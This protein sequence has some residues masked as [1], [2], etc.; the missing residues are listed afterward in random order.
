MWN[1]ILSAPK[2]TSRGMLDLKNIEI[3]NIIF[4]YMLI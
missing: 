1:P 3:N 2:I 4:T